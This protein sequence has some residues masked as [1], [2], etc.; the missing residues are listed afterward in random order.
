MNKNSKECTVEPKSLGGSFENGRK[1]LEL[2]DGSRFFP[3]LG[4]S[5]RGG[6]RK[7]LSFRKAYRLSKHGSLSGPSVRGRGSKN[8]KFLKAR[9]LDRSV[10][11]AFDSGG[12]AA[13][14]CTFASSFNA[15]NVD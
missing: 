15:D 12:R 13:S 4:G 8:L 11:R 7:N 6:G 14:K 5:Q 9:N 2:F 1:Q 3:L 10:A